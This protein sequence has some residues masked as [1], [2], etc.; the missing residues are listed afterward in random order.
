MPAYQLLSIEPDHNKI[1]RPESKFV[2]RRWE[3]AAVEALL[4][5]SVG[6]QGSIAG[7]V[8]PPGIG[9]S[10]MVREAAATAANLGMD[11]YWAFCESPRR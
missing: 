11:V 5:R 2:G 3:T 7:I 6:G 1:G 4:E 8:G 10:R 9:K